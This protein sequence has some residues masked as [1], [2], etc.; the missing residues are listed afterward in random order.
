M[1][2][3]K[4]DNHPRLAAQ[5]HNDRH[6]V[7]MCLEYAQLLCTTRRECGDD[8][9]PYRATHKNHPS[10]IWAR[11]SI[12]NYI[13]LCALGIELC[14]EYTKRYGRRHKCQ[15]VI[16]D[17]LSNSPD[18]PDIGI[19]PLKLAMPDEYKSDC[20]VTSYRNYYMSDKRHLADWR[21]QVPVWWN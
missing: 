1:N 19:T 15:D 5:Y 3:F 9:A 18:L 13:W 14:E 16:E 7:K 11:E 8:T 6:C 10:A 2:I 12:D 20:P 17:C 21:T 4:L